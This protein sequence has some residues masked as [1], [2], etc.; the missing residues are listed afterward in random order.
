MSW[1]RLFLVSL[2]AFAAGIAGVWVGNA[3]KDA[4]DTPASLH[5]YVHD[6]LALSAAQDA[7]LETLEAGFGKKR[8]LLETRL[9]QAN[10]K[11]AQAIDSEH[12]YGPA[13][14][15]AIANVH[16]EMGALQKSTIAHVFEMRE[17]LTTEQQAQ[18]DRKVGAALTPNRQ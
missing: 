3:Y 18:F 15:A 1:M 8:R 13:V 17:I 7:K 2:L 11:L 14:E 5:D 9:Q 4:A 10:A 12:E 16:Q 6:E